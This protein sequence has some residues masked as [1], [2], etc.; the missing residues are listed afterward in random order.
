MVVASVPIWILDLTEG[1]YTASTD[2]QFGQEGLT[3][4]PQKLHPTSG[5]AGLAPNS[6]TMH[7]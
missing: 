2:H 3:A 1:A 6:L 5:P 7:P 4:P